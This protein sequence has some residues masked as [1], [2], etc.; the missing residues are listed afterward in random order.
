MIPQ[1]LRV[2]VCQC[3]RAVQS[4]SRISKGSP[5]AALYAQR[6]LHTARPARE[7]AAG[8][9]SLTPL[10]LSSLNKNS[11]EAEKQKNES[12]AVRALDRLSSALRIKEAGNERHHKLSRIRGGGIHAFLSFN[13]KPLG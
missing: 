3:T 5:V 9:D 11:K 7:A 1:S 10:E 8:S 2:P 6:A 12:T 13:L 4:S